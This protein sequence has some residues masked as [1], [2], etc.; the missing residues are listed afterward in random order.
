VTRPDEYDNDTVAE[1]D[2]GG[3]V[4]GEGSKHPIQSLKIE[5]MKIFLRDWTDLNSRRYYTSYKD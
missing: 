1:P 5:S 3:V 4:E 2:C